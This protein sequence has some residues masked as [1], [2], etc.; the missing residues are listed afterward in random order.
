VVVLSLDRRDLC[1]CQPQLISDA[2]HGTNDALDMFA[3]G[4]TNRLGPS[5][6]DPVFYAV[7][8][9]NVVMNFVGLFVLTRSSVK[10]V[11]RPVCA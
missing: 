10:R 5:L 3:P 6:E 7:L 2:L 8:Q 1:R 9:F 11:F 4:Q